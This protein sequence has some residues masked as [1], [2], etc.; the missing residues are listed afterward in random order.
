ME[1]PVQTALA[2]ETT[3][4]KHRQQI[5]EQVKEIRNSVSIFGQFLTSLLS[6]L[7]DT[8]SNFK[9]GCIATNFVTWTE[10]TND[11]EVLSDNTSRPQVSD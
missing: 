7:E 6:Y 8:C 3:G 5:I 10:I 11:K 1:K 9:A 4:P 2:P